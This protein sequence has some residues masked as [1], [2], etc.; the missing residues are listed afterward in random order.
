MPTNH[1]RRV[2]AIVA[3]IAL[4][5]ASPAY[6]AIIQTEP[7]DLGLDDRNA[8]TAATC[9]ESGNGSPSIKS[10]RYA[11]DSVHRASV[12]CSRAERELDNPTT[13]SASCDNAT[14]TWKCRRSIYAQRMVRDYTVFIP[15]NPRETLAQRIAVIDYAIDLGRF[16][17]F[18]VAHV[19]NGTVCGMAYYRLGGSPE[20]QWHLNCSAALYFSVSVTCS[21]AKCYYKIG[22]IGIPVP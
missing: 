2:V 21:G 15:V 20:E 16:Q 3:P 5:M 12:S 22:D 14:G 9:S 11:G 19:I 7:V 17:G 4:G 8:I 6:T 18:D 10:Y 13:I 1:A